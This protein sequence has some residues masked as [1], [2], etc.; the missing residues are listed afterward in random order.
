MSTTRTASSALGGLD[1]EQGRGL[2]VLTQRQNFPLRGED[3]VLVE[4]ICMGRD[5]DP[6]PAAGDH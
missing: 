4:R 5:L 2:A 3:E 1:A 6:L